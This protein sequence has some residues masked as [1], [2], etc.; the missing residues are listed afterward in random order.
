MN[1]KI[2]KTALEVSKNSNSQ[3]H[4]MGCVIFQGKKIVS[5]GYNSI[6][7]SKS[8]SLHAE[9]SA[10]ERL[11]RSHGLLKEFRKVL[12]FSSR[13][14]LKPYSLRECRKGFLQALRRPSEKRW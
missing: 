10:I 7:G 12:D 6:L 3:H 9:A 1:Y 13:C 2:V 11:V 5:K 4:S 14:S 8:A